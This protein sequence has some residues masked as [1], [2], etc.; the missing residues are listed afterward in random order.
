MSRASRPKGAMAQKMNAKKG[1][2][3][4]ASFCV[5][6]IVWFGAFQFFSRDMTSLQ[7]NAPMDIKNESGLTRMKVYIDS[8]AAAGTAF[9]VTALALAAIDRYKSQK[10]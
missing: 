1:L 7:K 8:T 4:L 5:G 3:L 10:K 6:T 2:I 9:C